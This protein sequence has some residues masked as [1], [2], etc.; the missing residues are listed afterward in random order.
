L[1]SVADDKTCLSQTVV[2][3]F[4]LNGSEHRCQT[5]KF[6]NT[7]YVVNQREGALQILGIGLDHQ[8]K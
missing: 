7:I 2:Y 1:D 5:G 3:C 8:W 6:T 4:L